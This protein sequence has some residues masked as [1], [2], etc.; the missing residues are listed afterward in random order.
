MAADINEET[1]FRAGEGEDE[2]DDGIAISNK[3]PEMI[4]ELKLG[5]CFQGDHST[6]SKPPVN[7]DLK[8]VFYH[9]VLILKRNFQINVNERF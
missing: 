3:Q 1:R 4:W 2:D 9:K 8:V 6:C 5:I 7:I